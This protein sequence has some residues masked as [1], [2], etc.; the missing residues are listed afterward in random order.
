MQSWP[1]AGPSHSPIDYNLEFGRG[2]W[3]GDEE[4]LVVEMECLGG[5]APPPPQAFLSCLLP[6]LQKC[7]LNIT[8]S[9]PDDS[10]A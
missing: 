7:S 2:F 9:A 1:S 8:L 10:P 5:C 4:R 3:L 6:D